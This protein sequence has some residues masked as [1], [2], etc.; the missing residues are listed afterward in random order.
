MLPVILVGEKQ[1][2]G[3]SIFAIRPRSSRFKKFDQGK[4]K[5]KKGGF[6]TG[7]LSQKSSLGGCADEHDEGS[8]TNRRGARNSADSEHGGERRRGTSPEIAPSH[9]HCER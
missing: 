2:P 5:L 7:K 1:D 4:R 3:C 8:W 9:G 6:W